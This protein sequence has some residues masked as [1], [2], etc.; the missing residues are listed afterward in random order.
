[1]LPKM[2]RVFKTFWLSETFPKDS[3]IHSQLH[4]TRLTVLRPGL[5]G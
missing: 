1:M 5:P 2:S 3:V 4:Y